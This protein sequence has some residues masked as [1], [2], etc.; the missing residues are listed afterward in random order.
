MEYKLLYCCSH[1]NK[2]SDTGIHL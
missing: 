2:A 1:F